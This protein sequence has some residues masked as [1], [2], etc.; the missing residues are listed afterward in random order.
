M[1]FR[2]FLNIIYRSRYM[3]ILMCLSAV[4]TATL[5]TYVLS[6]KYKSATIVLI[7]PRETIDLVPKRKEILDFPLGYYSPVETASKTYTE[8]LKSG[9]VAERVIQL[10]GLDTMKEDKGTGWRYYLRKIKSGIKEFILKT[11]TLLRPD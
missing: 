10:L 3:I 2:Q 11:W 8:I 1:E 7:R 5:L 4:I 6:E 9:V